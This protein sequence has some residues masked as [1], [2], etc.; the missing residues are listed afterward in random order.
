MVENNAFMI[1]EMKEKVRKRQ[2]VEGFLYI[3][4]PSFHRK[5]H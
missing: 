2:G 4:Q 1:E 5:I 3:N